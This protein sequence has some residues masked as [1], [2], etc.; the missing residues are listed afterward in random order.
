MF[1]KQF[2]VICL[3]AAT[4]VKAANI[5]M[6]VTDCLLQTVKFSNVILGADD[7]I[8]PIYK[9]SNLPYP[10]DISTIHTVTFSR[11]SLYYL[12]PIIF[13]T[14][15]NLQKLWFEN[16]D[17]EEIRPNTFQNAKKLT[18]IYFQFSNIKILPAYAFVGAPLQTIYFSKSN[19]NSTIDPNAFR[20]LKALTEIQF[21]STNMT[22]IQK[23]SFVDSPNII[24]IMLNAHKINF[25]DPSAFATLKSLQVLSLAVNELTSLDKT[26]LRNNANL[27]MIYL[28]VNQLTTLD[29]SFFMYNPKLRSIDLSENFFTSISANLFANNP[30]LVEVT[31]THNRL[32]SLPAT[33]FQKNLALQH[34]NLFYNPLTALDKN[35]F[36]KNKQLRKIILQY[37]KLNAI[38]DTTFSGLTQLKS[39]NLLNNVCINQNFEGASAATIVSALA[40]CDANAKVN[41][42]P[43]CDNYVTQM[44]NLSGIINSV[45]AVLANL[46][47]ALGQFGKITSN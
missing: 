4:S 33:L 3:L 7:V 18:S 16:T 1:V 36:S 29:D 39:L 2:F 32:T 20:G 17:L 24:N 31:I 14:F 26:L 35:L 45:N 5:S 41:S 40:K 23:T 37:N 44:K 34:I 22:A 46:S 21:Y 13:T 28:N 42:A 15:L 30:G 43:N 27:N 6:N 38:F 47:Q 10:C 25:V 9:N 11:S 8:S 19:K 12:P